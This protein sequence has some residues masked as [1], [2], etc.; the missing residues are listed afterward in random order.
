MSI[1]APSDPGAP[2]N[3]ALLELL[4]FTAYIRLGL[5]A[6]ISKHTYGAPGLR[7]AQR[8]ATIGVR[9][10]NQQQVLLDVADRYGVDSFTLMRPFSGLFVDFEARTQESTWWEGV[11]KAVVGH[12]VAGDLARILVQAL[13]DD[14]RDDV[15]A[16]LVHADRDQDLR[17]T[18]MVAAA[19]QEDEELAGRL[20]LWGR[21]VVGEALMLCRTALVTHPQLAGLARTVRPADAGEHWLW[22][23]LKAEHTAR[24]ER[25]GLAS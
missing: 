5:F 9:V 16:A 19:A 21:R 11:L 13:P 25:M 10:G 12:G 17:V 8:M 18:Q 7:A 3:E 6:L 4:G 23:A 1:P 20:S 24:M 2:T 14:I 22:E 15:S